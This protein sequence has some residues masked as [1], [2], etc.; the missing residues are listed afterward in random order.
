MICTYTQLC[1][2]LFGEGAIAQTGELCRELGITRA[3]IITDKTVRAAGIPARAEQTLKDFSIDYEVYDGV[4]MDSPDYTLTEGSQIAARMAAEAVIGIGGGSTLDTAKGIACLAGS[5]ITIDELL[6]APPSVRPQLPAI[7]IPTTSGTGSESTKIAVVTNTKN[8]RK[9]GIFAIPAYAVVD[10]SLTVGLDPHITMYTGMDAFSHAAEALSSA[11]IPNPHSDLLAYDAIRRIVKW[12]PAAVR[13][14]EQPEARRQ[15]ALASNFAGKAFTDATVHLGHAMA[16]ALGARYHI[17]HGIGCAWSSPVVIE[18][19]ADA[20]PE[21]YRRVGEFL[22]TVMT[23][24]DPGILG[25]EVAASLRSFMREIGVPSCADMGLTKAMV[26][27]CAEDTAREDLASFGQKVPERKEIYD[28][29]ERMY[30]A[31][32]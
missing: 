19:M 26:L 1:P 32:S 29:L 30:D 17:P 20:C 22:N 2:V 8:H 3:L 21:K 16:H 15:L 18:Y 23:G 10:P 14:P 12:L 11:L 7:L 9:T 4:L 27:E 13:D 28:L 6:S 25:R 24:S 31:Y 5:G